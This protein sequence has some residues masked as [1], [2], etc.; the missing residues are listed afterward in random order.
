MQNVVDK[1]L[2]RTISDSDIRYYLHS[3]HDTQLWN[4]LEFLQPV[5]YDPLDMPYASTIFL[6]LHYDENCLNN[7]KT[8]GTQ[9]FEVHATNNGQMLKFDTCL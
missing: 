1:I 5:G 6:E 2:N 4:V 8:R 3:S 9:C 7:P